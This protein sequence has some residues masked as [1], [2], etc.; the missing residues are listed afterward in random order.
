MCRLLGIR[1]Q[2]P[3]S[4]R[5]SLLTAENAL[6][7]QSHEHPDGWGIGWWTERSP[8]PA[9]VRSPGA[10]FR[11]AAFA[12]EAERVRSTAVIAHV[13]K[14]SVGPVRL[15][16][17]HPFCWGPW[18]F[19]HNGTV[20]DFDRHRSA[21]EKE[22]DPD[23]AEVVVGDTDSARCFGIFLSRLARIADP[24]GEVTLP[25]VAQALAETVEA[26][27]AIADP[28]ATT[29]SATTFLV[30]NGSLML[31]YRRGRSLFYSTGDGAERTAAEGAP[32]ERLAIASEKISAAESWHEVPV[33]GMVGVDREMRIHRFA[34]G[35]FERMTSAA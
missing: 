7:V 20:A 30:G 8:Q 32:V 19:A 21:I 23:F 2:S 29:P 4:V 25:Q 15:E 22:I 11:E 35:A 16:N 18:L 1:S 13:R 26:V 27:A 31:A 24:G 6:L 17:A 14:A 3:C 34:P 12:S 10:A 28:G 5:R 33:D 9:V